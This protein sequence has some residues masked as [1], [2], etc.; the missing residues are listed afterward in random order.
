MTENKLLKK[1][2]KKRI[3]R[4]LDL[5][6]SGK[7]LTS[8]QED[9][10]LEL[11]DAADNVQKND[12]GIQAGREADKLA[13][14]GFELGPDETVVVGNLKPGDE[15][16]VTDRDGVPDKLVHKG[17][18]KKGNALLEDGQMLHVDP[19]EQLRIIGKKLK[20]TPSSS[21]QGVS[22][23]D[24]QGYLDR[25][26]KESDPAVL[27]AALE[28]IPDAAK[29]VQGFAAHADKIKGALEG[30][31]KELGSGGRSSKTESSQP[32]GVA[33]DTATDTATNKQAESTEQPGTVA[34]EAG[35]TS[36]IT[37]DKT[38]NTDDSVKFSRKNSASPEDF[39]PTTDGNIDYGEITPAI[40]K[41]MRR[42]AGK[43]RLQEGTKEKGLYHIVRPNRLQQI[44]NAGY[45]SAEALVAD[46]TK[47]YTAIYK[48]KGGSLI[49][50]KK[51]GQ[52][53]IAFVKLTPVSGG[54]YYLVETAFVSR[55]DYTNNK[56]L[57][58]EK[59]Q[60]TRSA[61]GTTGVISGQSNS[62][63]KNI[64]S[65]QGK[66]KKSKQA[67]SGTKKDTLPADQQADITKELESKQ[68]LGY[69]GVQQLLR[70]G[71]L[72]DCFSF[73]G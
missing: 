55:P 71:I 63:T 72:E 65:K 15:I 19:F 33:T 50:A 40:A 12:P 7:K 20:D 11:E 48:G 29:S 9:I 51:N 64:P 69:G 28:Q 43:I 2:G 39:V 52:A 73:A 14:E 3:N 53:K 66:V 62:S 25:L 59:P 47:K 41:V 46:V 16:V 36:D 38:A 67:S 60:S 23:A 61:T 45:D 1:V 30:R 22:D 24:I 54:E 37:S 18:D 21:S 34:K 58:W 4:V 49:L 27:N 6:E 57:L 70:K 42:Q 17:Y 35:I 44:K 26:T 31:L 5:V 68:A 13:K 10:W 32:L 56:E 8:I